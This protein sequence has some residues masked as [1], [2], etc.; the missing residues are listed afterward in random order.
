ME[1]SIHIHTDRLL[2][3]PQEIED[4]AAVGLGEDVERGDAI[5]YASS[6]I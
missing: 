3:R 2:V 4:P 6:G 1:V 5:K